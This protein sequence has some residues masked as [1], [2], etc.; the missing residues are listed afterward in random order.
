MMRAQEQEAAEKARID[1]EANEEAKRK[2][3]ERKEESYAR[4]KKK[5]R[6]GVALHDA[7]E[8]FQLYRR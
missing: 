2:A 8:E 3:D 6:R 1:E 7:S 4:G 5:V